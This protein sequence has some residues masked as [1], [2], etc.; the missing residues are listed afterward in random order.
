MRVRT[1]PQ[2]IRKQWPD[3]PRRHIFNLG[4]D[5]ETVLGHVACPLC[6]EVYGVRTG[7]APPGYAK[8]DHSDQPLP[9]TAWASGA[10]A[11]GH[12][13]FDVYIPGYVRHST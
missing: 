4:V 5:K 6:K 13:I 10:P 12:F 3:D 1:T 8:L 2:N 11:R 9:G 7:D